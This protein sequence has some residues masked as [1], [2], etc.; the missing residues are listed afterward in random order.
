MGMEG[1]DVLVG[2]DQELSLSPGAKGLH[3]TI[4]LPP[5]Y[6]WTDGASHHVEVASRNEDVLHVPP[7]RMPDLS[8]DWRIPIEVLSE[9]RTVVAVSGAM[10]FCP[11]ADEDICMFGPIDLQVPIVIEPG[12]ADELE[13]SHRVTPM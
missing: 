11:V 4:S 13:I 6:K 2:D 10:F 5:G 1:D 8:M 9:G 12:G 3:L 7:W